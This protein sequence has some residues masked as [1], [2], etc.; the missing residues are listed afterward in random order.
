MK[1]TDELSAPHPPK[2]FKETQTVFLND[3]NTLFF[4]QRTMNIPPSFFEY[5]CVIPYM[6]VYLSYRDRW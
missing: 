5:W 4:N 2:L 3:S 6:I 1:Q